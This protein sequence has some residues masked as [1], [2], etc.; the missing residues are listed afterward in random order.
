ML[1]KLKPVYVLCFAI[2]TLGIVIWNSNAFSQAG[3]TIPSDRKLT[4]QELKE[5]LQKHELKISLSDAVNIAEKRSG[6]K[7][8]SCRLRYLRNENL[9][10]S[11][12][13]FYPD[14][15]SMEAIYVHGITGEILGSWKTETYMIQISSQ[16]KPPK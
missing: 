8:I 2:V 15:V 10:Y 4:A 13:I 14:K 11:V 3:N 1:K 12:L 5:E 7:A 16:S 9:G 6:G